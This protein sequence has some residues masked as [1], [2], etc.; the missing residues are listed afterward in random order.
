MDSCSRLSLLIYYII[1]TKMKTFK[2][3]KELPW[4][5]VWTIIEYK[6]WYLECPEYIFTNVKDMIKDIIENRLSDWWLEEIKEPKYIY[7]LEIWDTYYSMNNF[8]RVE[9]VIITHSSYYEN[10]LEYWNVFLN[11]EDAE[12]ELNK[13]KAIAKI[14]K[15]IWEKNIEILSF[16]NIP[17]Y[18]IEY[19]PANNELCI[20]EIYSPRIWDIIF[21]NKEEA[22]RCKKECEKEWKILFG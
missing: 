9:K 16:N 14:K 11:K 8:N 1:E 17:W 20:T 12:K 15:W 21:E 5:E 7:E 22:E 13:R 18:S 2:L 4:L 19:Y 6:D 10:D 3:L